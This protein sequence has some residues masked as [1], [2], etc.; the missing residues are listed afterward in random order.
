MKAAQLKRTVALAVGVVAALYMQSPVYASEPGDLDPTFGRGGVRFVDFGRRDSVT[1]LFADE[2]AGLLAAGQSGASRVALVRLTR[3][4]GFDTGYDADARRTFRLSPM[5]GPV[6]DWE[7]DDDAFIALGASSDREYFLLRLNATTD[8][9]RS[10]GN[11]GLVR[12]KFRK[13]YVLNDLL[14]V[15]SGK[16]VLAAYVAGDTI[17]RAYSR[18]GNRDVDFGDGGEMRLPGDYRTLLYHPDGRILAVG[19]VGRNVLTIHALTLDGARD[20]SFGVGGRASLRMDMAR[21]DVVWPTRAIIASDGDILVQAD[22]LRGS[23]ASDVVI[24]RFTGRG[25]PAWRFGGG[26]AAATIDVATVDRGRGIVELPSGAIVIAGYVVD[27]LF[28]D[29]RHGS[30]MFI[31]GLTRQGR[32]WREFGSARRLNLG[33]R[34]DIF[35]HDAILTSRGVVV[36]GEAAGDFLV[37]RFRF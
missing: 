17:I 25:Q 21:G 9:D 31:A 2:Q 22:L 35:V 24:A 1:T 19:S 11:G 33:R 18:A 3:N 10:F 34:G 14:I 6:T 36:A 13:P 30:D 8:S 27:D 32:V 26:D 7:R 15:P 20:H 29:S 28:G 23:F 5:S 37:A 12:G 4:G 16:I